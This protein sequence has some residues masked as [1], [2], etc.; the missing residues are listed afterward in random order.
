MAKPGH[1]RRE[2]LAMVGAGALSIRAADQPFRFTNLDHLE[3][4][5][6]DVQK[7]AAFYGRV[8]GNTVMKNNRTSRRYINLGSAYMAIDTGQ[9]LRV[10]HI[11]AGIPGFDV[12]GM[13]AY[14]Q[15]RGIEYRDYPS[16]KDLSVGEP[17]GGVRL[18]LAT[19]NG[20]AALMSGTA[21]PESIPLNAEP[22]FRPSGLDHILLNVPNPEKSAAFYEKILGPVS[23]RNNNRI[24][25][26]VGSSRVGLLKTPDRERAGVSHFCVSA[27]AFD[28]DAA[29][30]ML[31][32]AGA[33]I[34]APEVAG[35]PEFRDPDGYLIQ[36]MPPRT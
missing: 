35:A 33:D 12:A 31:E 11:C 10:D 23:R 20:W 30:V 5:V 6:S 9:Q 26:Q 27:E 7:S 22:I 3:F 19:D 28:Y 13:H 2:L 24:W 18:Q 25:F 34:E 36:V 21:S 14:L 16:G 8:F 4:F 17:D 32:Q 1:T 29:M 15:Q